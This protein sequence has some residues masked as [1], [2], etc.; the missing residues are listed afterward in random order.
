MTHVLTCYSVYI[1]DAK[2]DT[3]VFIREGITLRKALLPGLVCLFFMNALASMLPIL[4]SEQNQSV[5]TV[6]M[7]TATAFILLNMSDLMQ[8]WLRLRGY[9]FVDVVSGYTRIEAQRRFFEQKNAGAL[10]ALMQSA[11]I[12]L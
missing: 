7:Y 1:H 10:L 6:L 12:I 8:Y 5:T 4:N 2:Q 9:R 11:D 3:P